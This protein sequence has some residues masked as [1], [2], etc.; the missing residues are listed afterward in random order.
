MPP[1]IAKGTTTQITALLRTSAT[2]HHV[3]ALVA[4][5]RSLA[6]AFLSV[7]ISYRRIDPTLLGLRR[8]DLA[9]DSIAE[10]FQRDENGSYIQ[11][12]AYFGGMDVDAMDDAEALSH[13]RRL[14][15]AK[16]NQAI[17]R[18]HHDTDPALGRILRNMRLAVGSLGHFTEIER[19]GET[20]LIPVH[21]DPLIHLPEFEYDRL[22]SLLRRHLSG[23]RIR[24]VPQ[25][26]NGLAVVLRSQNEHARGVHFVRTGLM[27][28]SIVAA[29]EP[30]AHEAPAVEVTLAL[31]DAERVIA[32]SCAAVRAVLH[33]RYV[34][35]GKLTAHMSE[36][37]LDV[38]QRYLL[39][40]VAG[41]DGHES[42]LFH[43]LHAE[44]PDLTRESYRDEHKSVIEYVLRLVKEEAGRR[45]ARS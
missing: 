29:R 8:D 11:L 12:E 4:T 13:L 28:R 14:V 36:H 45:M 30:P 34:A 6:E 1:R 31:S 44:V 22:E 18:F 42:S 9:I 16:V 39:D 5:C 32:Q 25:L 19:F 17:F 40:A 3:R 35:C 21:C 37:Y 27:F 43:R 20:F 15:F 24:T 41:R 7:K 2:E 38:V 26:L 10:I 33:E 23:T